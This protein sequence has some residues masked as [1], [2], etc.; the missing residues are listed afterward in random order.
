MEQKMHIQFIGKKSRTTTR[1]Q[2]VPIYLRV[3]IAGKRFEAA[4]QH[5]KPTEWSPSAGKVTG[6]SETAAK[7]K[8]H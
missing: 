2:L 5:V 6:R 4:T 1:H 8:W 3:A 7:T